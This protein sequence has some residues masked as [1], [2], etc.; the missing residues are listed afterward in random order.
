MRVIGRN[1]RKTVRGIGVINGAI[2]QDAMC[3]DRWVQMNECKLF[4]GLVFEMP[5]AGL[6]LRS[7]SC[8]TVTRR[9]SGGLRGRTK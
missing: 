8:I 4:G 2:T 7:T 1:N 6:A 9:E 3:K 5:V